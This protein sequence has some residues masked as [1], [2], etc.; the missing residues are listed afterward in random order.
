MSEHL[1]AKYENTADFFFG[2]LTHSDVKCIIFFHFLPE[3]R[4][5]YFLPAKIYHK[6]NLLYFIKINL[7]G[8]WRGRYII[9]NT[10]KTD[11][12]MSF[13][14]LPVRNDRDRRAPAVRIIDTGY[15]I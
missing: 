13:P 15:Y 5:G 12:T 7:P 2:S 3:K 14:L 4:P 10:P 9:R 6:Y 11:D 1:P 8:M